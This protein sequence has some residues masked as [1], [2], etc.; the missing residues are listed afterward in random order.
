MFR[1]SKKHDHKRKQDKRNEP[2]ESASQISNFENMLGGLWGK[3][4]KNV[5]VHGEMLK[6][7]PLTRCLWNWILGMEKKW[8]HEDIETQKVAE[9][10]AP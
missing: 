9:Q 7:A 1:H 6:K 8:K 4:R 10:V 5:Y 2:M 3:R